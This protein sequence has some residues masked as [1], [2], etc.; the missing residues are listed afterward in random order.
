MRWRW[1]PESRTP[2]SPRK[3]RSLR[4]RRPGIARVA[5]LSRWISSRRCAAAAVADVLDRAG[6]EDHRIRG[7]MPMR[8]AARPARAS[9]TGTPSISTRPAGRRR[10]AAAVGTACFCRRRWADHGHRLAGAYLERRGRAPRARGARVVEGHVLQ[11]A[12]AGRA[13]G[14]APDG[15]RGD[16]RGAREQLHQPLVAPPRAAGRHRPRTTPPRADEDD[17]VDH[18]LPELAGA[19][20]RRRS[21]PACPVQA[22]Q[23]RAEGGADDEGDEQGTQ[24]G[25]AGPP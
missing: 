21:P 6:R 2:R 5:R 4:Q 12:T 19:D 10:S 9:R 20:A 22:P 17:H 8:R 15:G 25:C 1:P 14:S 7:T 24:C 11:P 13:R 3:V 18:R 16:R 23:Q